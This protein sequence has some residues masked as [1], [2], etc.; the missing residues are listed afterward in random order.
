MHWTAFLLGLLGGAHCAGM[1]GPLMLALP[2]PPGSARR[3]VAGRLA[4]QLGR[5]AT[6]AVLGLGFGALGQG[7]AMA[8]T[9]RAIS[10]VLGVL[11]IA[12]LLVARR[13]QLGT[14][15]T[16]LVLRLRGAMAGLIARPGLPAQALLGGLNGLLP[17]GLV[18]VAGAG[19]AAEG[20][21]PGGLAYMALFGLGTLPVMLG[22]SLTGHLLPLSLRLHLARAMPAGVILV[23][24][25]LILRGLA[26]GI[27]YVSPGASCAHCH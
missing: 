26:L 21:L 16:R 14:P 24:A 20:S 7:F 4:H 6:Y 25:L 19:A 13:I 9:Q 17:C 18:Y 22:I 3:L 23:A 15:V 27:P 5:I 2:R 12:G 1:C 8:G 11:M 10:I